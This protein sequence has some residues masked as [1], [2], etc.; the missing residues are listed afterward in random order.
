MSETKYAGDKLE[1]PATDSG[2]RRP[3]Q[4]IEKVT[5][6]TEK[7]HQH[8]DSATNIPKRP[9]PQSHQHNDVT[10]IA[11]TLHQSVPKFKVQILAS[12]ES[13]ENVSDVSS[14]SSQI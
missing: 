13:S 9:P 6:I 2:C 12:T 10:N 5:N 3:I 11:V 4:Y 14:I 8:N 7:R 1:T